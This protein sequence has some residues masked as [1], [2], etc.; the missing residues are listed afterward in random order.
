M[1]FQKKPIIDV[2]LLTKTTKKLD[3]S[4]RLQITINVSVPT[5]WQVI[6]VIT[7]MLFEFILKI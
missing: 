5:P 2:E 6:I 1:A 4:R 7:L 3:P